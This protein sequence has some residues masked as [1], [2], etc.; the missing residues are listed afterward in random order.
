MLCVQVVCLKEVLQIIKCE[1]LSTNRTIAKYCFDAGTAYHVVSL[2]KTVKA[3][4]CFNQDRIAY[5]SRLTKIIIQSLKCL[6]YD[7]TVVGKL[8]CKSN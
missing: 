8:L 2:R 4:V 1:V 5:S 3:A 7:C 6:V